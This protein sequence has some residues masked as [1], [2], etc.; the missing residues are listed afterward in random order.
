MPPR[1]PNAAPPFGGTKGFET[2]SSE[3]TLA[4][5]YHFAKDEVW[6]QDAWN[7]TVTQRAPAVVA[8]GTALPEVK[9][10]DEG[11]PFV[12]AGKNPNGAVAVGTLPRLQPGKKF[13]T[14]PVEIAL[15]EPLTTGAPLAVFGAPRIVR[16]PYEGKARRVGVAVRDL[17]S[18]TE[19]RAEVVAADGFLRLDVDELKKAVVRGESPVPA[20]A[21]T[22]LV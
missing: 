22:L 12:V 8:R 14:P 6:F 4:E 21:L 18:G 5:S 7:R 13:V 9:A 11:H 10:L 1:S 15:G 17:A 19:A 2:L 16:V 20:I 3:A